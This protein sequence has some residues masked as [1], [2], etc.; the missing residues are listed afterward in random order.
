MTKP[1]KPSVLY[2]ALVK[3]LLDPTRPSKPLTKKHYDPQMGKRHPLRI[4]LTEDNSVNQKVAM[5]ILERLGY[6]ADVAGNGIEALEAL[7]RQ[8]YDV[9]LMDVQM[10][11]MDG[12]EATMII[13]QDWPPEK[14]PRIVAMTAHALKGDREKY[15]AYGMD[16]YISKP[17]QLENLVEVLENCPSQKVSGSLLS[18][19]EME[20][21]ETAVSSS[22]LQRQK[23]NAPTEQLEITDSW[24]IDMAGVKIALGDDAE[25]LLTELIPMFLEDVEPLLAQL[26]EASTTQNA[27]ELTR[28]AHTLKGSSASLG[29]KSIAERAKEIEY[30][31][32]EGQMLQVQVKIRELKLHCAQVR[33]V[34]EDKYS[35]TA[36]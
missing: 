21:E 19:R 32:R 11:E 5:R 12:V 35:I 17:I 36:R 6:R 33:T 3:A 9:V 30:M 15:L 16:D 14:R 27:E 7:Q 23:T 18:Q 4:L 25:D 2:E 22:T 29:L 28:A 26:D 24:P 10:P 13:Q 20:L 8:P 34:L 31:G 1:V